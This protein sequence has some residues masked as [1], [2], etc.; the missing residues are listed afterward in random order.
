[1]SNIQHLNTA[2]PGNLKSSLDEQNALTDVSTSLLTQLQRLNELD[3]DDISAEKIQAETMKSKA[4]VDVA[5]QIISSERLLFERK[6][7][8]AVVSTQRLTK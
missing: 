7:E 2:L 4:M 3:T 1:M 6:K 5:S 8:F